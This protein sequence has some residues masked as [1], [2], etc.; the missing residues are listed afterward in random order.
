MTDLKPCPF[1]GEDECCQVEALTVDDETLDIEDQEATSW[2]VG[3]EC[4]ALIGPF[5]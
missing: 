4:G 2:G 5:P 1:C 3:C